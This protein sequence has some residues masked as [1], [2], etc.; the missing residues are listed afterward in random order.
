MGLIR[1]IERHGIETKIVSLQLHSFSGVGAIL[2]VSYVKLQ[3]SV[4]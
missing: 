2:V 1:T 3:A 4:Y